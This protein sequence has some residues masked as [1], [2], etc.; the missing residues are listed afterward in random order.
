[1]SGEGTRLMGIQPSRPEELW[2]MFKTSIVE[3]RRCLLGQQPEVKPHRRRK[4]SGLGSEGLQ[5]LKSIVC[6]RGLRAGLSLTLSKNVTV[7]QY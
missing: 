7:L 1:M 5:K 6:P 4:P 3:G 2:T